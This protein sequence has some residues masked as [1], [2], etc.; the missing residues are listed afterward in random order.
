MESPVRIEN[1][2]QLI[3]LLTEAAEIE[4][5]VMC[6]YMFAA[7]SMKKSVSEG[8]TEEQVAIIKGWRG[9]IMQVAIQEMVHMCLACNLLTA[10]GAAPHVRRPNLPSSPKAYG[11]GFSLEFTTFNRETMD[12]FVFIERPESQETGFT[13]GENT[14]LPSLSSG[15]F[16]DIFSSERQYQTIG[17]LYRGI[18]DGFRYLSQK[19]GEEGLFIGPPKAQIIDQYFNL[20]GLIPVTDLESAIA[21]IEGIVEQGEGARLEDENSHYARFVALLNEY[22]EILKHDPNFEPGR[23]VVKN[24]YSIYPNDIQDATGVS[25]IENPV[26]MDVCNLFDGCYEVLIQLMGRLLIGGEESEAQLTEIADIT[27]AIMIDVIGPLG[28]VITTL[29]A[30]PSYPGIN[31]GPSFRFSR[32]GQ[33][34]PH[35]EAARAL[36]IERLKELSAYCGL[37]QGDDD[38][39][40]VLSQVRASLAQYAERLVRWEI[41]VN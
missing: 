4:H 28:D 7:F 29:P 22:D 16:S 39:R 8:I 37:I 20:P 19:Y 6:C 32:D 11:P 1:R 10:I 15:N 34:P 17:H 31:A 23:R 18:E 5:G 41:K 3:Y 12:A 21:A 9:V 30:G 24:P 40:S 35:M 38:L 33:A 26:T 2:A 13:Q 36:F 25:L 27:V 14:S